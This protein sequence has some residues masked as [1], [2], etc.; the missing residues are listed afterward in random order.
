M[1]NKVKLFCNLAFSLNPPWTGHK[2]L[3]IRISFSVSLQVCETP[4]KTLSYMINSRHSAI[5]TDA[6][7]SVIK[8]AE[9]EM[10]QRTQLEMHN[11]LHNTKPKDVLVGDNRGGSDNRGSPSM[12]SSS[13]SSSDGDTSL[14][15][16]S[17]SSSSSSSVLTSS[18]LTLTTWLD[19]S[20]SFR[21]PQY[22]CCPLLIFSVSLLLH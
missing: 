20:H 22:C 1:S 21:I 14:S 15:S 13:S 18:Y 7:L 2:N 3:T 12:S 6:E 11:D 16:R 19:S 9:M 4:A 8:V 10:L 17:A 5:T